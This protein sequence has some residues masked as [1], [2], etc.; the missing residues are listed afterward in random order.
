MSNAFK[1]AILV[2]VAGLIALPAAAQGVFPERQHEKGWGVSPDNRPPG[3]DVREGAFEVIGVQETDRREDR[4]VFR[5][6]RGEGR[7][8]EIKLKAL[9]D[10]ARIQ[11]IQ[12]KFRNGQTQDVDVYQRLEPGMETAPIRLDGARDR[13]IEEVTVYKRPSFRP[14]NM[15]FE[16]SGKAP[17]RPPVAVGFAEIDTQSVGHLS[18]RLVFRAGRGSGRLD[19][20]KIRA[21]DDRVRIEDVI[22]RFRNGQTQRVPL[23][24]R[25][26]AG[27]ETRA[28]QLE[29][30]RSR[31]VEEVIVTKRPSFRPGVVR[32][33]LLGRRPVPPP[34]GDDL[35]AGDLPE[36]WV[37]FGT[38]TVG[39]DVDRDV[40]NIGRDVGQFGKI[41]LNAR[42]HDVLL[43]EMTIVYANGERARI[44]VNKVITA[45]SRTPPLFL[46]GDRFI[47]AM[48]LVYQSRTGG[49]R[50]PAIVEVFGEYADGWLGD[51]G[52]R[53]NFNDG[54]V[55][56]GAQRA[57][58][59][60]TDHD[61]FP[62]GGKFGR[63]KAVKVVAKGHPIKVRGMRIIYGNGQVE[64]VPL[65]AD[66]RQNESTPPLPVASGQRFIK[67][68]ELVY[69]TKL[70]FFGEGTVEVWGLQ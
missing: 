3:N 27:T 16:L 21:V 32:L 39:R 14:G 41:A 50:G 11:D 59:F 47:S 64:N 37:L 60:K 34:R 23:L 24:V 45:G 10:S 69:R 33:Q 4:V 1:M 8:D 52:R 9:D 46:R 26:E 31:Q 62:V 61:T 51:R 13:V 63:F 55:L 65:I 42:N 2:A 12:I 67:S 38:Q 6:G 7:F 17:P 15:R 29:G 53:R 49:W 70:N 66:L 36:G 5:V 43:R 40:I 54:W 48:E 22:I 30:D 19:E 35:I 68:V 57:E 28:I 56:L 44:P 58:I 20:I 18:D 25:L